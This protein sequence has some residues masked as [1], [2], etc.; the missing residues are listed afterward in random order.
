MIHAVLPVL[1]CLIW[2]FS[3]E[4]VNG[5]HWDYNHQADWKKLSPSCAGRR[6]S[7]IDIDDICDPGTSTL[8]KP[9]LKL[10][11]LYYNQELPKNVVQFVNNGHTAQL[12]LTGADVNND[13]APKVSGPAFDYDVFQFSQLHFHW[14]QVS[15][16]LFL[17]S[18]VLNPLIERYPWIR[19][20]NSWISRGA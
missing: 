2:L 17:P 14:D 20:F 1:S 3:H 9:S 8:V 7:P 10:E 19:A 6:Q 16:T 13:W 5:D 4:G 18:I 12:I 11:F 15:N